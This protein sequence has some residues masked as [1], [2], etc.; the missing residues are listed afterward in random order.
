MANIFTNPQI[1]QY[2]LMQKLKSVVF[3]L[4]VCL[5][6]S[7][8][9]QQLS[10]QNKR[11]LKLYKKAELALIDRDFPTAK[12]YFSD[13]IR[14]D[15]AFYEP[16]LRLASIYSLYQQKDSSLIYTQAYVRVA[17]YDKVTWGVWKNLAY[18][19]F[20]AGQ[21]QEADN[22]VVK[23]IAL[24]PEY[25]TEPE[26]QLLRASIA[27]SLEAIANPD[28]VNFTTLPDAINH[29]DLQYFPVLT[30]DE[31]TLIFYQERQQPYACG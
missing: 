1:P 5:S 7:A 16:Y 13:C 29:F 8:F 22:A 15:P 20:E 19:A 25:L 30:I 24:K 26:F 18:L 23:L 14:H 2:S 9:S 6:L 12:Q 10:T 11:S 4:V 28:S 17:P 27:F 31:R 3:L 21:Y